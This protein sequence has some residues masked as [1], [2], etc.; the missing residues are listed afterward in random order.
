MSKYLTLIFLLLFL[1]FIIS[2]KRK[3]LLTRNA[4]SILKILG[5]ALSGASAGYFSSETEWLEILFL[6]LMI[7]FSFS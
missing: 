5:A 6:V 3:T 2:L 1:V 4:F 7:I